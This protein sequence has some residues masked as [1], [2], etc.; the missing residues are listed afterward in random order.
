MRSM[1]GGSGRSSGRRTGP[2]AI[3]SGPGYRVTLSFDDENVY[4]SGH[5]PLALK[6]LEGPIRRFVEQTLAGHS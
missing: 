4:A 2:S 3:L 6:L 1:A 5:V